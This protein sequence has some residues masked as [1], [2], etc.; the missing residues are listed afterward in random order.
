MRFRL[1]LQALRRD[2]FM[3]VVVAV[4]IALIVL[5]VGA[6]VFFS[7][8]PI[9][10]EFGSRLE[11]P[12]WQG[13]PAQAGVMG[14]DQ[15]GR[16]VWLRSLYGLRTSY[17]VGV[18]AVALGAAVG[19]TL[20][21]TAGYSGGRIDTIVMRLSD[22]QLSFPS[23]LLAMTVI[24]ILRGGIGVLIL[25]LGLNS[26]MLYARVARNLVLSYRTSDFVLATA[27]LGASPTRIMWRHLLPNSLAPLV[28]VA[29]LE[30]ARLMLGEAT[31]SFLG[32]GVKP[33]TISLGSMLAEGRDY[34]STQWWVSTFSGAMLAV[35]VLTVNLFGNWLERTSDPLN[36]K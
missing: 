4:A 5:S 8:D 25:V 10:P 9:S 33:P 1:L 31:L 24:V 32:F 19:I 36:I 17:V 15:L 22:I 23:L 7:T 16:P 21:L 2:R 28:A 26:W 3:M 6:P 30:L 20:G 27:S 12:S 13:G 35:A 29:T 11:P 18:G 34:L 14:T